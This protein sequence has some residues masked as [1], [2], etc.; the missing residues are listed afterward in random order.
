MEGKHAV[1]TFLILALKKHHPNPNGSLLLWG[2][3]PFS[4]HPCDGADKDGWDFQVAQ[5]GLVY[6]FSS[7]SKGQSCLDFVVR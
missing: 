7:Y 6:L 3:N 5:L 1:Q 4:T 2:F